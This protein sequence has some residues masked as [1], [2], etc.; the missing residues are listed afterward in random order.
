MRN[1]L[2]DQGL[3]GDVADWTPQDPLKN[4]TTYYWRVVPIGADGQPDPA[5]DVSSFRVIASRC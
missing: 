5:S 2:I 4:C 1:V 3:A